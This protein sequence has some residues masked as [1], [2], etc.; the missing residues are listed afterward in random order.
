MVDMNYASIDNLYIKKFGR[1]FTI[2]GTQNQYCLIKEVILNYACKIGNIEIVKLLIKD[3]TNINL[4]D[5]I[6]RTPLRRAA[7]NGHLEIV[8]LL[9]K[10]NADP[11][12]EDRHGL[13]PLLAS[14]EFEKYKVA[15]FLLENDFFFQLININSKTKTGNTALILASLKE[16]VKIV[17]IL[18]Q[19]KGIDINIQ[20]CW[21]NTALIC[22]SKKGNKE[23][24]KLLIERKEIDINI[25][26]DLG[27]TA[28]IEASNNKYLNIA[29]I[30]SHYKNKKL[31]SK[32][33][34]KKKIIQ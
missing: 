33:E 22:A 4:K 6:N 25:Q 30:L 16:N 18:L 7:K 24:V 10:K 15:E 20:N 12:I 5:T 32:K 14:L 29:F 9:I 2:L 13:T 17:N 11:N 8:K 31:K 3:N 26:N 1:K 23:I 21:K 27:N 34:K 19:R 28:L